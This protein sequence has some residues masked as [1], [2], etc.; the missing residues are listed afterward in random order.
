MADCYK[1]HSMKKLFTLLT[2]FTFSS[3]AFAQHNHTNNTGQQKEQTYHTKDHIT[4]MDGK[5]ILLKNGRSTVLTKDIKL[6]NGSIVT[7]NGMLHTKDG[8][9]MMMKNGDMIYMDG[10]MGRMDKPLNKKA[11]LKT[12]TSNNKFSTVMPINGC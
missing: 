5:M 4:M 8:K 10:K 9:M 7:K 6:S 1:T 2:A 3:V 11:A 12:K